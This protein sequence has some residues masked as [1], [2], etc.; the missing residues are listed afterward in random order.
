MKE[1]NHNLI[2]MVKSSPNIE[3]AE[4]ERVVGGADAIIQSLAANLGSITALEDQKN[5]IRNEAEQLGKSGNG[6]AGYTEKMADFTSRLDA[7]SGQQQKYITRS[8]QD[9]LQLQQLMSIYN[10]ANQLATNMIA[11]Y[12]RTMETISGNSGR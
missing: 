4:L 9:Q 12:G 2:E 3:L 8:N 1:N 7:L 11:V 5:A 6:S 10:Q